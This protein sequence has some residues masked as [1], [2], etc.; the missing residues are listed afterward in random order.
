MGLETAAAVA[1]GSQLV[2]QGVSYFENRAARQRV[3]KLQ[4][5]AAGV[6]GLTPGNSGQ[7]AYLQYLRAN[8]GA[9]APFQ[10]DAS[11]AFQ[12]LRAQDL[13]DTQDQVNQLRAGA[14][15][16]GARFGSGFAAREAMLRARIAASQGTRNAGIA[17]RGFEFASTAGSNLFLQQR[18]QQLQALG[19]TAGLPQPA[20]FGAQI[21]QTGSDIASLLMLMRYLGQS[22]G[23]GAANLAPKTPISVQPVVPYGGG[24]NS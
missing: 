19:F 12:S 7:D 6:V 22:G 15:S 9:N 20:G 8:P 24:S 10:F 16:L 4:S 1:I 23:G 21:G 3:N 17:Q 18:A 13:L 11:Q 5:Q 14:G 2:G